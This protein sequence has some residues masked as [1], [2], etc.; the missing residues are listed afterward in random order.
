MVFMLSLRCCA[1]APLHCHDHF[2]QFTAYE[3]WFLAFESRSLCAMLR[4]SGDGD[5]D[6]GGDQNRNKIFKTENMHLA[7]EFSS[8]H[9]AAH[10]I[11][12]CVILLTGE[13]VPAPLKL[14]QFKWLLFLFIFN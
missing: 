2:P 5:D 1:T 12:D 14:V 9:H 3:V 4:A 7:M 10:I 8:F 6:D 13:L 11:F